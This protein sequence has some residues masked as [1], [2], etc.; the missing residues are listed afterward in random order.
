M[1]S[2]EAV[3][4]AED[5]RNRKGN[6]VRRDGRATF[7][8]E[9]RRELAQKEWLYP[10]ATSL[11][12]D[13]MRAAFANGEIAMF[14]SAA[15][16][17]ATVNDN[18]AST[19]DWAAAPVPVPDGEQSVRAIMNIGKPYSVNAD[20]GNTAAAVKVLEA[21]AGPDLQEE[22][23]Q[24]GSTFPLRL[25]TAASIDIESMVKPYEDYV[26]ADGDV[27]RQTSPVQSLELQGETYDQVIA[28]LVIGNDDIASALKEAED[29]YNAAWKSAVDSGL[30]DPTQFVY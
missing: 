26:I 10:G 20:A 30:V 17:V 11:D 22:L 1:A 14:V 25:D 5:K 3:A 15:W 18:Y 13:T 23:A 19:I 27:Q 7:E 29:R 21:I 9:A 2:T 4:K 6:L 28:R 24:A 12:N 8:E 16:D